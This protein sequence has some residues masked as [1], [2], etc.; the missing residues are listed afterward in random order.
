MDDGDYRKWLETI[1]A[2]SEAQR[3][4]VWTMLA[5]RSSKADV[6]A[7]LEGGV[8]AARKCVHCGEHGVVCRGEASGL[9]RFY[10]RHCGKTFNALTGTLRAIKTAAAPL[11]GIVEADETYVLESHK[12]SRAWKQA[13]QGY[14]DAVAPE[15]KPRNAVARQVSAVCP[16]SRWQS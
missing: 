11:C 10:C 2:L 13:E 3:A 1:D 9:R 16:M 14:P 5:G 8:L 7:A 6:I 12:G 4:D 15:R